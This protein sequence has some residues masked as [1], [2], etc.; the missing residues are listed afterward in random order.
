MPRKLLIVDESP[1]AKSMGSVKDK[2]KK[3]VL[4]IVDE[5]GKEITKDEASRQQK[6]AMEDLRDVVHQGYADSLF[7]ET[8]VENMPF[9]NKKIAKTMYKLADE[10][11]DEWHDV[12][13]RYLKISGEDLDKF[14]KDE[15]SPN[16]DVYGSFAEDFGFKLVGDNPYSLGNDPEDYR[17]TKN[18]IIETKDML[19]GDG[20]RAGLLPGAYEESLFKELGH[21]K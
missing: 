12:M 18:T 3:R 7:F 6:R 13:M 21:G 5:D 2:K 16:L 15:I 19:Y 20:R 1:A 4:Q 10:Y 17:A 9:T 14:M 11:R 8:L